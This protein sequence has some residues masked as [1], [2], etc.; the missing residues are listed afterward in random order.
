MVSPLIYFSNSLHFFG[1]T[2]DNQRLNFSLKEIL[3]FSSVIVATD[4]VAALTFVKEEKDPKLFSILFGEGVLN[5]A[6]CIVLYRIV[7][8]FDF[9]SEE[10]SHYSLASMLGSFLILFIISTFLGILGGLS[11]SIFLKKMKYFRLGRAQESSII[12]FFAFMTYSCSE[13]IGFSPIISLLF[14]GIFMSQYAYFNLSFQ[15]REES[16][17]VSKIMSNIAEGFVFTYLGLTSVSI[18]AHSIS[19]SFIIWILI[20]VLLGRLISIYGISWLLK[21]IRCPNFEMKNGDK[22]IMSF[23][24]SIRGAIAFGLAISI[25]SD[26]VENR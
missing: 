20:F 26:S 13:L 1:L 21:I 17:I 3:L 8:N 23:A 18:T 24:G 10:F 22:G 5:D 19:F 16:S 11:C 2:F 12:I 14:C 4:T 25:Q 15:A 6:V 9:K 7:K